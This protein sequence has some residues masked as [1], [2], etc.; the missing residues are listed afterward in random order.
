MRCAVLVIGACLLAATVAC[1]QWTVIRGMLLLDGDYPR[2]GLSPK[3]CSTSAAASCSPC[4][5]GLT[6]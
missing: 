4:T 1:G 6:T 3:P 2:R 5:P